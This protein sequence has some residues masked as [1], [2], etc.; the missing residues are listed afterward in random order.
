MYR[1]II[2]FKYVTNNSI[3]RCK[4]YEI[5]GKREWLKELIFKNAKIWKGCLSLCD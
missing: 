5:N 2:M 3:K 1:Y 4:K